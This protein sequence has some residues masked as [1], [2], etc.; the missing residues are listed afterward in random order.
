[1]KCTLCGELADLLLRFHPIPLSK[2]GTGLLD[3]LA[4]PPTGV[5]LLL[6]EP[7]VR[8]QIRG[9]EA[10]LFQMPLL[11]PGRARGPS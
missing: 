4:P 8:R 6:C 1:M 10:L 3:E 5:E 7:C 9:A 11:G 2:L